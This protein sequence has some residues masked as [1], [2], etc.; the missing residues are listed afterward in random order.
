ME[1]VARGLKVLDDKAKAFS[2]TLEKQGR[3]LSKAGTTLTK[4]ISGPVMGLTAGMGLLASKTGEY[5]DGLMDLRD[6]TGLSTDSL[7]EYENVARVAGVSF[8]GLTGT[9]SKLTNQIPEIA[10]G[11]GPAAEAMAKLGVNVFDASGQVRDMN[12]LFPEILAQLRRVENVTTRNAL[13][14]DLF[15]KSLADV[16][17]V[18]GMTTKQMEAARKE[19]HTLG[20][21][22]SEEALTAANDLRVDTEKLKAQFTSFGRQ[23]AGD[24]V[25]LFKDTIVPLIQSYVLPVMRSL[26]ERVKAVG[27]WFNALSPATKDFVVKVGF[28]AAALGP[29]ILAIGKTME[30]LASMR[31]VVLALN[32]ALLSNPFIAAA[33][34]LLA[35]GYAIKK[36]SD[37]WDKWKKNLGDNVAKKQAD[38]V[39]KSLEE[40]I[41]LYGKLAGVS[42]YAMHP[43]EYAYTAQ[44]IKELETNLADLGYEFTGSFGGKVV[45]AE[46]ALTDLEDTM[47]SSSTT[48]QDLKND[49]AELSSIVVDLGKNSESTAEEVKKTAGERA[50]IELDAKQQL[51]D[52]LAAEEGRLAQLKLTQSREIAMV[53]EKGASIADIEM[54]HALE[55]ETLEG[56][57]KQAAVNASEE[58]KNKRIADSKEA[59]DKQIA[60][61]QSIMGMAAF[62]GNEVS[63]IFSSIYSGQMQ[64]IDDEER[65]KLGSLNAQTAAEDR[66]A[67]IKAIKDSDMTEVEKK[68]ALDKIALADSRAAAISAI[69]DQADKKR[70]SIAKKQAIVDKAAAI[71]SIGI[72]TAVA[73]VKALPNV[74]LSAVIGGIGILQ[75]GIVASKPMPQFK[76]GGLIKGG[77]GGIV[78][79]IGES[80]DDELILPMRKGVD[81]LVNKIVGALGSVAMPVQQ[82]QASASRVINLNVGTLIGDDRSYKELERRLH[83][84]TLS[85][86]TRKG[87][88]A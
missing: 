7:Q 40:I 33:A 44:K 56:E 43:D 70:R 83:D 35:V 57:V 84:I 25:P 53:K 1:G 45:A 79:Q 27:D 46:N 29:T 86:S 31:L 21:V 32:T 67:E 81:T 52:T 49:V 34:A 20:L 88:I 38:E 10:K 65:R 47:R 59:A 37:E 80:N 12:E 39:K 28:M 51:E 22:M 68:A 73:V 50:K 13:A 76:D 54:R 69:E 61:F 62:F 5:A 60:S 18:L 75:A 23:L 87:L 11:T 8:D 6:I 71:F 63:S 58:V 78:G 41:P 72:N 42:E 15:G 19:A 2:K 14:Q 66:A 48:S 77:Q 26:A 82:M 64:R 9:I 74:I 24:F 85:E 4:F 3:D 30:L 16:A 17:P 55:R 36:T